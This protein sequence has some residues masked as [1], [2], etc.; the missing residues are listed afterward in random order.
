[1]ENV[2]QIDRNKRALISDVD[3]ESLPRISLEGANVISRYG[4]SRMHDM[5]MTIRPDGI[6]FNMHAIE[7]I[8]TQFVLPMI[9]RTN[10]W[11]I[12]KAGDSDDKD[13][14]RWCSDK[15]GLRKTRKISGKDFPNRLY[16]Y[17]QWNLGYYYKIF[18]SLALQVDVEDELLIVFELNPS[19]R[20]P[21]TQKGREAAGV[22]DENVGEETLIKL[23]EH[24][25]AMNAEKAERAAKKA[26]GEK[27]GKSQI[28][29][30]Q[31]TD[32]PS[33]WGDDQFGPSVK[34]Y[35][36]RIEL[37]RVNGRYV[38]DGQTSLFNE[39]EDETSSNK[40]ISE[41]IPLTK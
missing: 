31:L 39:T 17:M 9:N 41:N 13:T 12:I 10:Q 29:K 38:I 5:V 6:Q 22:F 25:A 3:R 20:Y 7:R 15:D 14:Q 2:G 37:N 27:S 34:D 33:A 21:L 16:R 1:M 26:R 30:S 40:T 36:K 28:S 4:F 18:G 11:I 8:E 23:N 24:E 32:I 19:E 35:R